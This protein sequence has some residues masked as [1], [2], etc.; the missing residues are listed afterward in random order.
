MLATQALQHLERT[1]QF[2]GSRRESLELVVPVCAPGAIGGSP[3]VS[4]TALNAG[5]DWDA[6]RVFVRPECELST[7]TEVE[8]EAIVRSVRDGQSWHAYQAHK[9]LHARIAELEA[10]VAELRAPTGNQD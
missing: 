8:R 10:E 9:K 5:I 3:Y 7:L 4:V 6:R 1:L 2:A